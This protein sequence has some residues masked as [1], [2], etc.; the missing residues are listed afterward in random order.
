MLVTNINEETLQDCINIATGLFHPLDGFMSAPDYHSVVR[1][2]LLS[3]GGVWT[4][5]VTLDVGH[6]IFIKAAESDKLYLSYKNKIVAFVKIE[7]C[8]RVDARNDAKLVFGTADSKHPG[9]CYELSRFEYRVGGK[10]TITDKA[11][12]KDALHPETTCNHFKR[13]GWRTVAGFQTRNPVHRAHE[14]LQ[15][16]A[17]ELCDGLFINPLTGWRK[18]GDFSQRAIMG[19]YR[20]MVKNYYPA[21]RVYIAELKTCMRYAGPREAVFHALIRRNLGCTHFI[22]GRD[23]AGVGSYYGRYQAQE[24]AQSLA[25]KHHLG[26]ELL[27]LKEP[28]FC[29]K[30]G[31]MVTE[32]SCKHTGKDI[33]NISGTAIREALAKN[34]LPDEKF[35][36]PDIARVIVSLGRNKFVKE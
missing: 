18:P 1:D 32:K 6:D 16:I 26:I 35:L 31:Q 4:I 15:R 8:Y 21:G 28:V 29:K 2:C 7:D 30:C 36:R 13:Q 14:H 10:V 27:L 33:V 25:K 34:R 20:Q 23:H 17:L 3:G 22:I 11:V 9:V 12:L 5:P 19:A 24:F